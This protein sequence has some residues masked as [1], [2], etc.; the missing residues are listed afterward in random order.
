[1]QFPGFSS[2][3]SMFQLAGKGDVA[4]MKYDR[5]SDPRQK[6]MLKMLE[7]A[8]VGRATPFSSESRVTR[9]VEFSH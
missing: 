8:Q 1:M 5:N 6:E 3:S 2:V 4:S 7:S 9:L